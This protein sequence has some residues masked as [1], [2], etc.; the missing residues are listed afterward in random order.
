MRKTVLWVTAVLVGWLGLSMFGLKIGSYHLVAKEWGASEGTLFIL[1]LGSLLLFMAAE[2]VGKYVLGALLILWGSFQ[3][4][5]HW[6]FTIFGADPELVRNYNTVFAENIRL[7]PMSDAV[8]IPDL[9]H[10]VLM[11]LTLA[12]LIVWAVYL[13]RKKNPK[14]N[15]SEKV[16]VQ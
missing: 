5:A 2:R 8:V 10:F 3:F 12:A 11:G 6:R 14:D 16:I 7:F 13:F 9:Y 4:A 1:L 15:S